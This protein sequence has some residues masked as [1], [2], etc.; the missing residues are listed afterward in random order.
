MQFFNPQLNTCCY[1]PYVTSSLTREWVCRLQLLLVLAS[2]FIIRSESIRIDDHISLSQIR[3]SP[4]PGG[5]G[6][7]IYVPQE[8]SGPVI[9]PGTGFH[10]RHLL[11]LAGYGGDI[12]P[13]LNTGK[14]NP[15]YQKFTQ[16][17]FKNSVP[18]L[19]KTLFPLQCCKEKCRCMLLRTIIMSLKKTNI[20][21]NK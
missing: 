20:L 21:F 11:R 12:R 6:P 8:K 10:F 14:M 19:Q 1:S 17:I 3:D 16:M 18:T 2:A 15:T 4:K 5:P 7:R 9:P 13:R